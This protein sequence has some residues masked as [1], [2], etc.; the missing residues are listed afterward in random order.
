MHILIYTLEFP[1]CRGGAGVYCRDLAKGLSDLGIQVT[2]LT[3]SYG[4]NDVIVDTQLPYTLLRTCVTWNPRKDAG[5]LHRIVRKIHPD[6]LL[7]ADYGAQLTVPWAHLAQS[8]PYAVV[9]FRSEIPR[10]F[11]AAETWR[12]YF[13]YRRAK[14][15]YTNA[16]HLL[17]ISRDTLSVTTQYLPHLQHKIAVVTLGIDLQPF[18]SF[19][20][21][22]A[23]CLK[24]ELGLNERKIILS[25]SRLAPH[26]HQDILI[27]ALPGLISEIPDVFLLIAGD[28]QERK[29][30]MQ[31][32]KEKDLVKYVG[33]AGDIPEV[34]K[35]AYYQ[36]S[37][38]F[39]LPSV[40]EGFGL[41]YLEANICGK[42]VLGANSGGTPDAIAD[43]FSGVLVNPLDVEDTRQKLFRLLTDDNYRQRLEAQGYQRVLD[44]FTIQ[45]MAENTLQI[46]SKNGK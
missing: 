7:V 23:L 45:H 30:L 27:Q 4:P 35:P 1:P 36:L 9:L 2:V 16:Q 42:S 29:R 26:K 5:E 37:D 18:L 40:G 12:D 46:L 28:G 32:V 31:L 6:F 15:L 43:N 25:L 39:A 22:T 41:V 33:F 19:Q 17:A 8:L 14:H 24:S 13:R 10:Q 38:I 11:T 3:K 21:E 34:M 20:R 44:G